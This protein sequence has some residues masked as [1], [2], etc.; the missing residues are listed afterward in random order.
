[1]WANNWFSAIL[2]CTIS[3]L[4]PGASYAV[5]LNYGDTEDYGYYKDYGGKVAA[6]GDGKATFAIVVPEAEY[7]YQLALTSTEDR[8]LVTLGRK[9][10]EEKVYNVKATATWTATPTAILTTTR[11]HI[12]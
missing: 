2:N 6:N 7:Y 12:P 4:T 5:M 10:L 11:G 9:A 1:L 3:G 8:K